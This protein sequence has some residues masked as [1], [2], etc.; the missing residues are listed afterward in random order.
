MI[1]QKHTGYGYAWH[2]MTITKYFRDSADNRWIAVSSW[3]A[4]Y[5]INYRTHFDA[6]TNWLG[7]GLMYFN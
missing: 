5:S 7:G 4:R 1:S 2:W 6:M 3:G